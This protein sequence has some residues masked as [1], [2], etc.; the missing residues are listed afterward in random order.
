MSTKRPELDRREDRSS[1]AA[2]VWLGVVFLLALTLWG[3]WRDVLL[4]MRNLARFA[5]FAVGAAI[6]L[7]TSCYRPSRRTWWRNLSLLAAIGVALVGIAALPSRV[8]LDVR[9]HETELVTIAVTALKSP[10][11]SVDGC[12]PAPAGLSVGDLGPFDQVCV[13]GLHPRGT[14][15]FRHSTSASRTEG[16]VYLADPASYPPQSTCVK[17]L[18]GRWS[19]FARPAAPDCP[20]GFHFIGGG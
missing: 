5:I 15:E 7:G 3:R 2:S 18:F 1:L 14:V 8:E 12:T 11:D 19:Q 20:F 4:P 9:D 16:L 17:G 6:A 10:P 13:V